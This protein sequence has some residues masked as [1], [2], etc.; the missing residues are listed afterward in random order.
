[1][2]GINTFQMIEVIPKFDVEI[3][4]EWTRSLNDILQIAWSFLRNIIY[5]LKRPKLNLHWK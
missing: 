4:F 1:M 2:A 3:C 5:R